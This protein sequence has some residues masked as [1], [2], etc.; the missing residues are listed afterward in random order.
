LIKTLQIIAIDCTPESGCTPPIE[1]SGN[2]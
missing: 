1:V 2:K